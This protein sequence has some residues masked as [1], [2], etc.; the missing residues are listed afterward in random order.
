MKTLRFILLTLAA[1]ICAAQLQAQSIVRK[2]DAPVRKETL[3]KV[4]VNGDTVSVILPER[5]FGRFDRG[6][7]NY[8]FIPKGKWGF[9]ITA[10]YGELQTEDISVLSVLE[11]FN[12][13]G[14]IYSVKPYMQYF[15]RSNQAVGL[16][17]D[18]SRGV[19]DLASLAVDFDDDLNFSLRDV[20]YY[21]Q[22]FAVS[23]FYR[24]YVGLDHNGRFGIFNEVDL[25][26]GSGSSRFKRQYNGVPRDTRTVIT[27][28]SLNF[29]PGLCVFI[30]DYMSF[31]VS[32]G[33]FGLK[34]Q[35]E[36]Q[37]TDGI[38]EGTRNTSGANFRFNIFNINFGLMVVI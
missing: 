32:F 28:A 14:K 7:F 10:A 4:V 35:H 26:F 8:I 15:F 37:T 30:Q 23:T 34:Y 20:S 22:S 31:N 38:D 6:L 2:K 1:A 11:D 16:K 5:N 25:A 33:V 21:Q 36:H 17:F 18:Y 12:F 19:A 9:G 24:N 29:S 27:K 3:E 13:K